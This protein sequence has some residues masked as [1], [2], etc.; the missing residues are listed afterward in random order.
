[1]AT[2][3][4]ALTVI[5]CSTIPHG[6][7]QVVTRILAWS[8]IRF[9]FRGDYTT[10][11]SQLYP[12]RDQ[13]SQQKDTIPS[14][15]PSQG[16]SAI[17]PF[18]EDVFFTSSSGDEETAPSDHS[19]EARSGHSQAVR[20]PAPVRLESQKS[21]TIRP[22]RS[23]I[24]YKSHGYTYESL[25]VYAPVP[26]EEMGA[27]E[28]RDLVTPQLARLAERL[29]ISKRFWVETRTR[30]ITPFERGFWLVDCSGWSD[31]LRLEGWSFLTNYVGV[32]AAG[33]GVHTLRDEAFQ[34]IRVYC[35]GEVTP[36]I[37]LLLYLVSQRD[38][39]FTGCS[40]FD[41]SGEEVLIMQKKPRIES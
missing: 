4:R 3:E 40:W 9:K 6:Y 25:N 10:S 38:I 13:P 23:V 8:I 17:Y 24:F 26:R 14:I 20:H 22:Q 21:A 30:N 19:S 18:P 29:D 36:H 5:F 35:W 12:Y 28:A 2:D 41:G 31:R 33:W 32:G 7:E 1:M 11:P 34:W 37:Y 15:K 39:L 27:M 16:S